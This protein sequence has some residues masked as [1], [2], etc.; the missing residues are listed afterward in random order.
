MVLLQ[1]GQFSTLYS[2]D[3]DKTVWYFSVYVGRGEKGFIGQT[4]TIL[5]YYI[6]EYITIHVELHYK[7]VQFFILSSN[8]SI[9]FTSVSN[10][11]WRQTII[12]L[13][14]YSKAKSAMLA[15]YLVWRGEHKWRWRT[16]HK[17]LYLGRRHSLPVD[18]ETIWQISNDHI[19]RTPDSC[20]GALRTAVDWHTSHCLKEYRTKNVSHIVWAK[21][22]GRLY[23]L[24][25]RITNSLDP[26][27]CTSPW[28][29]SKIITRPTIVTND[30]T[31]L[32]IQLIT[33]TSQKSYVTWVIVGWNENQPR[34]DRDN[35]IISIYYRLGLTP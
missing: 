24:S 8:V 6:H 16:V 27:R 10:Y 20:R 12:S 30:W 13:Y 21:V 29:N 22:R 18:N 31:R 3:D 11:A 28:R 14:A 26:Y 9:S 5:G 17:L 35:K 32:C 34:P 25:T 23:A 33:S 19:E 15:S 1:T 7:S 4:I 2:V